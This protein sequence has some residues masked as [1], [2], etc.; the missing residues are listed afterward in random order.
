MTNDE[1]SFA[2]WHKRHAQD[3]AERLR[4]WF[5]RG[6]LVVLLA[7]CATIALAGEGTG[8]ERMKLVPGDDRCVAFVEAENRYGVYNET[9]TLLVP[10]Y[11]PV[12]I[13]Y[14]TI[15]AHGPGA[16]DKI[17]VTAL[18]RDLIAIPMDAEIPD[19]ETFRVCLMPY[20]GG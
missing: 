7:A 6:A 17:K 3:R 18:P 5:I 10:G 8:H 19:D 12:S 9:E 15:G 11:G 4:P 2:L 14:D 1:D 13:Y 16:D 20:A